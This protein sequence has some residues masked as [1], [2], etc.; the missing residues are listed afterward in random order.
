MAEDPVN[1]M[2]KTRMLHFARDVIWQQIGGAALFA[3]IEVRT[4]ASAKFGTE[5]RKIV[6]DPIMW[7]TIV[8]SSAYFNFFKD[9]SKLEISKRVTGN[10]LSM[11]SNLEHPK[12]TS[13]TNKI[14]AERLL[15]QI[16]EQRNI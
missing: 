7:A 9:Q 1:P 4:R 5:F 2:L 11:Q 8:G 13:Y 6:K 3:A 15:D 12:T 10:E 14:N 16:D